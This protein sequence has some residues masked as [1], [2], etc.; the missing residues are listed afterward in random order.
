MQKGQTKSKGKGKG[1]GRGGA[2]GGRSF[3]PSAV[4]MQE[5]DDDAMAFLS[6]SGVECQQ[7]E[8]EA[9]DEAED[10]PWWSEILEGVKDPLAIEHSGKIVA[11]MEIIGGAVVEKEKVLVLVL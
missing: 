6:Q 11:L 10:D 1:K 3:S 9:E 2:A 5:E 4:L 8:D 7:G